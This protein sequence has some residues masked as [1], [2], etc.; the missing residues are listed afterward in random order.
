[1]NRFSSK[2]SYSL[3]EALRAQKALR[4][5]VGLAPETFPIE[6]FVGMV[7]DEIEE[8]RR[9]GYDDEEIAKVIRDNSAIQINKADI[10]KN[11]APPQDR[12]RP[13]E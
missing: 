1:M 11:Y 12:Q 2:K 4:D 7:S 10:I 3:E 6:S 5:L 8:L 9:R 13:S